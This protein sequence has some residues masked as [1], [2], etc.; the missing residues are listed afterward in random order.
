MLQ[1]EMIRNMEFR[2]MIPGQFEYDSFLL[3]SEQEDTVM[4][5]DH[6]CEH[7]RLKKCVMLTVLLCALLMLPLSAQAAVKYRKLTM[8]VGQSV[9]L[10]LKG[11]T[12][13]LNWK[14][15]S[16]KK[17]SVTGSGLITAKKKG[18]V[19]V[20]VRYE[21]AT[22]KFYVRIK[23]KA[24]NQSYAVRTVSMKP[25]E[26][27][28]TVQATAAFAG[29]QTTASGKFSENNIIMVGD[30]RFV[31]MHNAV[32]GQASWIAKVGMGLSWLKSTAAPKLKKMKVSG[33]AVVFNL[34]VNDLS[35]SSGY[36]SFLN[37]LGSLLRAKGASVYFM[38]VNPIDDKTAAKNG[39]SV[40]NKSVISFNRKLVAGLSGFGII[41]SY[42]YLVFLTFQTVDGIHYAASTYRSIYNY[43]NLFIGA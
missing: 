26:S 30:S 12:Q 7:R 5:R 22:Y 33:K 41:D 37:T 10:K 34:G 21:G 38:T 9:Q 32:G 17:L 15:G 29:L 11:V 14:S 8:R 28:G 6:R 23:K 31:G 35:E 19:T 25:F 3:N 20:R 27:S 36:I 40:R 18:K 24:R 39:Y 2:S 4:M 16:S 42:D 1:S 13:T 43:M